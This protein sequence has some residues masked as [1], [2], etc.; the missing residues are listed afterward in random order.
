VTG[1]TKNKLY[2][3][4]TVAVFLGRLDPLLM[5]SRPRAEAR[6]KARSTGA[7]LDSGINLGED[8]EPSLARWFPELFDTT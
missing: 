7:C 5:G 8:L 6:L 3:F 1:G 2:V 4:F